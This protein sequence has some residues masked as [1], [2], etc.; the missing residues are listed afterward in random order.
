MKKIVILGDIGSGKSFIARL[1]GYPVFNADLE[2]SKIYKFDRHFFNK[3]KKKF[4][5]FFKKFPIKKKEIINCILNNNKN[6]N[7]IS[8]IIH[9]II[10]KKLKIFLKKN[11]SKKIVVL[12]IPLFLE[13]KLNTKSDIIIFVQANKNQIRKRLFKRK[14][15]NKKLYN[16]FKKIQLPLYIKKKNAD[17]VIK[18]NFSNKVEKKTVKY[19][20]DQVLK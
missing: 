11:K 12:D 10:R 19:I 2:V 13:N 15:F 7:K 17:F 9:P 18:N 4:P 16:L 20:L 8:K 1:F 3:L 6:L 14:G 5:N